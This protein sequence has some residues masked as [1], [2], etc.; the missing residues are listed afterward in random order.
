MHRA[1][2]EEKCAEL[3][4]NTEAMLKWHAKVELR[5]YTQSRFYITDIKTKFLARLR[6]ERARVTDDDE[7]SHV[8]E[9]SAKLAVQH[10]TEAGY[11]NIKLSDLE[12]LRQVEPFEREL[13]VMAEV[14]AYYQ[15]AYKV[16]DR[17][18]CPFE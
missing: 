6:D 8:S 4:L 2:I 10:L 13:D 1:I 7:D 18:A 14:R 9:K 11:K 16:C 17:R 5:P 15:V 3:A 12:K